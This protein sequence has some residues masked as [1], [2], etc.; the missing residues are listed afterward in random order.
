MWAARSYQ[1]RTSKVAT[2]TR[3]TQ[4]KTAKSL[5]SRRKSLR[6]HRH[7]HRGLCRPTPVATKHAYSDLKVATHT[8][9]TQDKTAKSLSSRRKS[10]RSHRHQHRGLCRPTP[11]ATKHAY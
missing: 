9:A 5:S 4:D 11:V 8:R 1:T 3:A 6:S 2:H 7:Q 10:L